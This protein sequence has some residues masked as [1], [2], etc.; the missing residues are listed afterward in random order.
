MSLNTVKHSPIE[1]I[2]SL[3]QSHKIPRFIQRSIN[4]L[5]KGKLIYIQYVYIYIK[6][7]CIN[8]SPVCHKLNLFSLSFGLSFEQDIFRRR[9]G[10]MD[11]WEIVTDSSEY[12]LTI[13]IK[14]Q[15]I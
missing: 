11:T 12:F 1:D 10:L 15:K 9:L 6:Q 3:K 5:V 13:N 7:K 8:S 14:R 4:R 2:N